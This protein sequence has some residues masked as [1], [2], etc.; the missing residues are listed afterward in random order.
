MFTEG[1]ISDKGDHSVK[2]NT[3]LHVMP[4]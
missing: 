4:K 3:H 2:L 1:S